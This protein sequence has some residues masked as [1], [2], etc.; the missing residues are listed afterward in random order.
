M[1]RRYLEGQGGTGNK[2][3]GNG[4]DWREKEKFKKGVE[5]SRNRLEE[6]GGIGR[7]FRKQN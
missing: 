2:M 1:T 7:V 4:R 5:D 6:F 3:E